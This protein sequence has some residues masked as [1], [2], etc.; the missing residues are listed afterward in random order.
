MLLWWKNLSVAKKL[1]AVVGVMAV[2][3]AAELMTL[4]FAM[5]IMSSL[6]AFIAGEAVWAN[7]QKNSIYSL[8]RFASTGKES[9]FR[10]FEKYIQIPLGYH[11]ARIELQKENFSLP[12][13]REAFLKGEVQAEDIDGVVQMIR[14]FHNVSYLQQAMALWIEGDEHFKQLVEAANRIYPLMRSA[15]TSQDLIQNEINEIEKINSK[16]TN[17]ENKFA[18]TLGAGSRWLERILMF[19]LL[20]AVLTVE[21]TGLVLTVIFTKNLSRSLAELTFTADQVGKGNFSQEVPVRSEDELGRLARAINKMTL[22]LRKNVGQRVRAEN[23]NQTKTAYL[24]NMSHEIRT[25]LGVILGLVD[26]L[27]DPNLSW[28]EHTRYLETIEKTGK[29]L[30]RIINDILDVSK[31]ETGHVE[32]EKSNFFLPEF[33]TD[34][35]NMMKVRAEQSQNR[36]VFKAEGPLPEK[37]YT[38]RTRLKQIL[39]NLINNAIKFTES[40][41]ISLAYGST[42][43]HVY[44]R[45]SDTGIGIAD[46]FKDQVFHPYFQVD[47]DGKKRQEGTGLGL[48]LSKKLARALGG[49]VVLEKSAPGSG[50]TF[51]ITIQKE[52]REEKLASIKPQAAIQSKES[53][54]NNKKVLVVEDVLDN[55]MLTKL[56]LGRKGMKVQFANNGKEGM[57]KALAEEF[58]VI[59]MDMQMPVMDGYT[60]TRELRKQGFTKPI[61]ALTAHAMKEDRERCLE[62]GCDDY[63]TKPI[64]SSSLYRSIAKFIAPNFN[65]DVSSN[66]SL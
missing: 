37:I 27:K 53:D 44:F 60:A 42:A 15:N 24:A 32:I 64:E 35:Q 49:D 55:Q 26:I 58:D 23:A 52:V 5:S 3:I 65:P 33:L 30:T 51:L 59:L 47:E 45:V 14:R 36:L 63:L 66:P 6:R 19:V 56:Y 28:N 8:S 46:E 21:F 18:H 34:L 17:M 29:N 2:L 22:D 11:Q 1:Y 41:A 25:P 20:C 10:D 4:I 48:A 38:D 16:L 40:G 39:V 50:T 31:V 62:A 13:V 61:I 54:L 12:A 7:A 43:S 9:Y 57:V